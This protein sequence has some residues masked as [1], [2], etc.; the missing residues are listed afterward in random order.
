[1]CNNEDH[2]TVNGVRLETVPIGVTTVI[3]PA[4][5]PGGTEVT[6]RVALSLTILAE[7][8][9]ND[10]LVAPPRLMPVIV[11]RLPIGALFGETASTV[12]AVLR[13]TAD[14]DVHP[15]AQHSFAVAHETSYRPSTELGIVPVTQV[16]PPLDVVSADPADTLAFLPTVEQLIEFV[17]E[18]P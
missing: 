1:M 14:D 13:T 18:M 16:S 4:F 3:R 11:T 9:S 8:P 7:V 12:G 6:M 5:A 2:V 17:H 10:T 15:T